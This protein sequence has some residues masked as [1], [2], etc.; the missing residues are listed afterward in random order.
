MFLSPPPHSQANSDVACLTP[1]VV[2]G[3]YELVERIGRGGMGEV[4][5]GRHTTLGSPVAIKFELNELAEGRFLQEGRVAASLASE[6]ICHVLDEGH[7]QGRAFLV[8]EYLEGETLAERLLSEGR[9]SPTETVR[10][11]ADV[12]RGL[13]CAHA[14]GVVHRDLKPSNVF[15]LREGLAKILDFGVARVEGADHTST[16][17]FLGTLRYVSPEQ[18][19]DPRRVTAKSDL[20]SLGAITFEC[21]VGRRLFDQRSAPEIIDA[22]AS[23]PLPRPSDVGPAS[24]R[25]DDWFRKTMQRDPGRRPT[26]IREFVDTLAEA[27]LDGCSPRVALPSSTSDVSLAPTERLS[28]PSV[29]SGGKVH[30]LRQVAVGAGLVAVGFGGA[31]LVPTGAS[32]PDASLSSATTDLDRDAPHPEGPMPPPPPPHPTATAPDTAA[33]LSNPTARDPES[34]SESPHPS[35]PPRKATRAAVSGSASA[36]EP[37]TTLTGD[38]DSATRRDPV[39]A[40]PPN[41]TSPANSDPSPEQSASANDP[42]S[43]R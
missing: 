31:H 11:M 13:A 34:L 9:L 20:W 18:A 33:S 12:G 23:R 22:I 5:K 37:S 38:Q 10:V 27:L 21:I 24:T 32:P 39:G 25:F 40:A 43:Y 30:R 19:R 1:G 6:A 26:S 35:T 14:A 2:L 16:G 15:L 29:P 17:Q 36:A 3:R 7:Y 4:W 42:F 8:L 28:I 41:D